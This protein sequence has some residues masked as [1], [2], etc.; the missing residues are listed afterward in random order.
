MRAGQVSGTIEPAIDSR[1]DTRQRR[2]RGQTSLG[3]RSERSPQ[4][5]SSKSL[6]GD[7]RSDAVMGP[8]KMP[9]TGVAMAAWQATVQQ[10]PACFVGAPLGQELPP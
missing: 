8:G 6:S 4:Q 1:P 7:R 5:P 9:M 3:G 2:E 10:F